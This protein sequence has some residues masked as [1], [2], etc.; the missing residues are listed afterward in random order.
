MKKKIFTYE[1]RYAFMHFSFK[2]KVG[3]YIHECL[4]AY[5]KFYMQFSLLVSLRKKVI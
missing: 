5:F 3:A 2:G 4:Y 1:E